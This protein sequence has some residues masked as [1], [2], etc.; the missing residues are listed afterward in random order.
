MILV[1]SRLGAADAA[2]SQPVPPAGWRLELV[3]QAPQVLHPGAIACAPDGRIFVAED[4]MDIRTERADVAEGRILCFHPD[5]RRTVFLDRI[6]AAFGLQYLEGRLYVLHNPFFSAWEDAGEFGTNRVDL[7]RNTNP[8]WHA[9][10]WN[11]HVPANFRLGLDGRFYV[12]TG[13][14]GLFGAVGRD[15]KRFDFFGGGIFRMRPDGTELEAFSTGVRN[16]LDVVLDAEDN[17]FTYDNTDE[18]EWMGRVTQMVDGGY[19]G[20]PHDFIPRQPDTL[21]CFADLGAGAATGM[22]GAL[23][24]ALPEPWRGNLFLADFGKRT[25]LRVP[26]QPVGGTFAVEGPAGPVR[27]IAGIGDVESLFTNPPEDFRP[28][29]LT[30]S[31][32]GRSLLIGDWQHRDVKDTNAIAG[33]LWRLTWTGSERPTPFPAWYVPAA[34]GKSFTASNEQ[35]ITGL[36]HPSKDVR[37]CAQRRLGERAAAPGQSAGQVLAVAMDRTAASLARI[38][39]LWALAA[40][41][42]RAETLPIRKALLRLIGDPDLRVAGQAS[43]W[44][45]EAREEGAVL[46]LVKQLRS[47]SAVL[48]FRAATALGRIGSIA[49]L[50]PLAE[51][52][53]DEN[54]WTRY[55]A[56]TA[57]NRLGRG[58]P[59]T[60]PEL[61][62]LLAQGN[63]R[64][65]EAARFA[66]QNTFDPRLAAA[67]REFLQ[68][69]RQP[70][71]ARTAAATLLAEACRQPPAWDGGWW[72]YHP[73]RTPAPTHSVEWAGTAQIRDDLVT[74]LTDSVAGV[75]RA[76]NAG[77]AAE[78]DSAVVDAL[79]AVAHSETDPTVKA[80]LIETLGQRQDGASGAL[81]VS[82]LRPDGE[83][84]VVV[85]AAL[86]AAGKIGGDAVTK[87]VVAWL[88]RALPDSDPLVWS[89]G[90]GAAANLNTAA[91]IPV[92]A[93]VA[94]RGG[95]SAEAAIRGLGRMDQAAARRELRRLL[96]DS[97]RETRKAVLAALASGTGAP[98]IPEL[99]AA[100]REP[101]LRSEALL[102]LTRVPQ[103][104]AL[105]AYLDG[106]GS[107]SPEQRAASRQAIKGLQT[108]AR[109]LVESR[110]SELTPEVVSELQILFQDDPEALKG[111][112]FQ[113]RRAVVTP[114]A[115]L[116]FAL[117]NPGDPNR[118]ERLFRDPAG[119][120]CLGCHRLKGDGAEVGPDL[121]NMGAQFGLRELAESI[122]W[123]SRVV[124]E[125]YQPLIV[126]LKEGEEVAGLIKGESVEF[127]T[128]RDSAGRLRQIAKSEVVGRR[129]SDQSLMPEGLQAG[130][131][132]AEFA[133]LLAFAGRCR[134]GK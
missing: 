49:A 54:T 29:G 24:D 77:L 119:L 6:Y 48:R 4:P 26:L 27:G 40:V 9:L 82:A 38:H 106:L 97:P 45:G 127:L 35:L 92:L 7:V 25:V 50:G 30:F 17:V 110:V 36:G 18:H 72:A 100:W 125:G 112:L 94:D 81:V 3:A 99:M 114:E 46:G 101:E 34:T 63:P 28:V 132:L 19:Y 2:S 12:A 59:A 80:A 76:A 21:W 67:L 5:G 118:G 122:L 85:A 20:Y 131:S 62:H 83:A 120:N 116:E 113:V 126:E 66:L 32:D 104:A 64:A 98:A 60:W 69:R 33:R 86:E 37:L 91:A 31:P 93:R 107:K 129:Q 121:S 87:A 71:L 42:S 133:D 11:D 44:A 61:V 115:Y 108:A 96:R 41:P 95:A 109:P 111:P 47:P 15:G 84:P 103:V 55:A 74:A 134:E 102:A 58:Q 56:F 1:A 23:N 90:V 57:L 39:A 16:I 75:R 65:A 68:D 73:F 78:P 79:R 10:G 88:G 13:D 52:L 8:N 124:R 105:E 22:A 51:S 43:R 123:P 89:K 130:L 128:L 53:T 70:E 117:A 14:K